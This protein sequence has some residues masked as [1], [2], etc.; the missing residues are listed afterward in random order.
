MNGDDISIFQKSTGTPSPVRADDL[1]ADGG[2]EGKQIH[3]VKPTLYLPGANSTISDFGRKTGA[4]LREIGNYYI[5]GQSLCRVHADK[6]GCL[7]LVEIKPVALASVLEKVAYLQKCS[8]VGTIPGV[9]AKGTAEIVL[10]C[11]EFQAQLPHISLLSPC[12]VLVERDGKL[13]EISSYDQMS[14]ILAS[15]PA[16]EECTLDT[17][18]ILLDEILADFR[19]ASQGD[20]ARALAALVTPAMLFGGLLGGR[21]PMDLGEADLSQTGKGFR[22]RLTCAVYRQTPRTVTQRKTGVGSLEESFNKAVIIGAI[23]IELDNVRGDID[24]PAIES[25][26]TQDSFSARAAY[27][28]DVVIDPRRIVLMLT[29]NKAEV[30]VDL[31]NRCSPVRLLHQADG[32][33][34]HTYPE[35]SILDR[36]QA[37]QSRYLGAIFTIVR[38]WHA[39]GKPVTDETRH[40]FREWSQRL[41]WIAQNLLG[42]GA[43]IDGYRETAARMVSP[44]LNF[45]RDVALIVRKA[46]R[47]D[48]WLRTHDLLSLCEDSG[49]EIPG[50]PEGLDF[51]DDADHKYRLQRLGRVIAR[52]FRSAETTIVDNFEIER[53][54][55]YNSEARC[56]VREYRFCVAAERIPE[57]RPS[58][59]TPAQVVLLQHGTGACGWNAN[60]SAAEKVPN[61][62]VNSA[63]AANAANAAGDSKQIFENINS[64]CFPSVE[65]TIGMSSRISRNSTSPNLTENQINNLLAD[66]SEGAAQNVDNS[67][68]GVTVEVVDLPPPGHVWVSSTACRK[69]GSMDRRGGDCLSCG[70]PEW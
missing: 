8:G 21:A 30:S 39:A 66:A 70:W 55:E 36:V 25:F 33:T 46:A 22:N 7:S 1:F 62:G 26:L 58:A 57:N 13:I 44:A 14:G 43:L 28:G 45:L 27:I 32:F 69:C 10:A 19:F 23:F 60:S 35:G 68:A 24:S 37:H 41:D 31:M 17:A 65:Q 38:A 51:D 52:C 40:S 67:S 3:H 56:E 49:L 64:G 6:S 53:R 47:L 61:L 54:S 5:R 11:E 15:G 2:I 4:L 42:A 63:L 34:F 20:R 9:C 48:F 50:T 29:S 18:Q 12:P 59:A 16:A